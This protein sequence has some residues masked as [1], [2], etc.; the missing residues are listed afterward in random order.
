[1]ESIRLQLGTLTTAH[2][3]LS[4]YV[5]VEESSAGIMAGSVHVWCSEIAKD[6]A[7]YLILNGPDMTRLRE[8]LDQAEGTIAGLAKTGKLMFVAEGLERQPAR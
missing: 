6:R 5:S 3:R 7:G 4:V 8:M 1:M 2:S